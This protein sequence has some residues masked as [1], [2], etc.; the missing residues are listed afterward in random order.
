MA[1]ASRRV[2][3]EDDRLIFLSERSNPKPLTTAI[4]Y[5]DTDF[6][7][8]FDG[9]KHN[10]KLKT[11]EPVNL[12]VCGFRQEWKKPE[13]FLERIYRTG[14]ALPDG[15]YIR[16]CNMMPVD[17]FTSLMDEVEH[18]KESWANTSGYGILPAR[19]ASNDLIDGTW[20]FYG[21]QEGKAFNVTLQHTEGDAA[22][23]DTL[24][25]VLTSIGR[26]EYIKGAGFDTAIIV[27]PL[28][29]RMSAQAQDTRLMSIMCIMRT[30]TDQND[31]PPIH[32]IG[33][34]KLESTAALAIRP[35][36]AKRVVDETDFVN[37]QAI[38][39]RA[40]CQ[41]LAY[42]FLQPP[43]DQLFSTEKKSPS[44]Y[45]S[46]VEMFLPL[47]AT[48]TF[49]AITAQV[50]RGG[51]QD[52][53]RGDTVEEVLGGVRS[54]YSCAGPNQDKVGR[55]GEVVG[56]PAKNSKDM[57]DIFQ[58]R[59]P[60][61]SGETTTEEI[62]RA[63][64]A[65]VKDDICIGYRAF[66][67]IQMQTVICPTFDTTCTFQE[68]DVL[69][70]VARREPTACGSRRAPMASGGTVG[71]SSQNTSDEAPLRQAAQAAGQPTAQVVG[72][73]G[74]GEVSQSAPLLR[75]PVSDTS[76]ASETSPT[77]KGF[78]GK[79]KAVGKKSKS[80][81]TSSPRPST[82]T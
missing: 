26:I 73:N 49:A 74:T 57:T 63:N 41:G 12:L 78:K 67:D 43:I 48:V 39:A 20:R 14:K 23:Y 25:E 65:R 79:K 19:D 64:L 60:T 82:E 13:R 77:E 62:S 66:I 75:F 9:S 34:N 8:G 51:N 24:E 3:H 56:T 30:I 55:F 2:I 7:E 18:D 80:K 33:E 70:I 47:G 38:I 68:G 61:Q 37:V 44:I 4:P 58:V 21:R 28:M 53:R 50:K 52:M 76:E 15:S 72:V 81:A 42:P 45:L 40:M 6:L 54:L 10:P 35:K 46:P 32:V 69:L 22:N 17:E 36:C 5:G 59:F 31:L 71:I 11:S 27:P 16:F 29:E 1:P